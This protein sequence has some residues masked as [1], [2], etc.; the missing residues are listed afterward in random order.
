MDPAATRKAHHYYGRKCKQSSLST[1]P[2]R[3]C[4][5]CLA[6]A[7][8]RSGVVLDG[9]RNAKVNELQLPLHHQEVGGLEVGVDDAQVVDVRHCP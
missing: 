8:D 2:P 9:L 1:A 7:R 6:L 4:S 5:T 3:S